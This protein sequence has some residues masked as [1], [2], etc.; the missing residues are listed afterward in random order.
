MTRYTYP[1]NLLSQTTDAD[2]HKVN[3]VRL[4]LNNSPPL[5]DWTATRVWSTP[6]WGTGTLEILQDGTVVY[7]D[8]GSG[9]NHPGAGMTSLPITVYFQVVDELGAYSNIASRP[10]FIHSPSSGDTTPP[11]PVSMSPAVGATNVA[12]GIA[13]IDL[14]FSEAIQQGAAGATI[15]LRNV[16]AGTDIETFTLP[17][18]VGTGPGKVSFSGNQLHVTPTANLPPGVMLALRWS[19]AAVKDLSR[20]D[21]T[22]NAGD[23]W[24]F[25]TA[26]LPQTGL[27]RPD[28]PLGLAGWSPSANYD[29]ALVPPGSLLVVD[30]TGANGAYT[31]ITAAMAAA[32]AGKTIAVK[33]GVYEEAFAV[34]AG[35]T[36]Q[37]YGTDKPLLTAQ[38]AL[39]GFVQCGA[40]DA[41]FLG[42]TLG[43]ASSPV[44]KKTGI[45]KSILPLTDLLG[46]LPMEAWA[47]L[48]NAQDRPDQTNVDFQEDASRFFNPVA[49]GGG[50]ILTGGLIT[51]ITDPTILTTAR[52]GSNAALIGREVRYFCAPNETA[53]ATITG[54]DLTTNTI[55]ITGKF[56]PDNSGQKYF[57]IQNWAPAMTPG[58]FAYI[59]N[60]TTFDL[61]IYPK[62]PANMSA[63]TIAARNRII[64]IP[65]N[66]DGVTIR[67]LRLCGASGTG[68]YNGTCITKSDSGNLSSNLLI[69]NCEVWGTYSSSELHHG[70][71][72]VV[73]MANVVVQYTTVR[74]TYAHGIFPNGG[75]SA[76]PTTGFLARR[77]AF[78]RTGSAGAKCYSM[79]NYVVMHCYHAW[80][81]YRSH[82]NLTNRY[83]GGVGALVYGCR[84]ERCQGYITFQSSTN[85]SVAFCH[86]PTDNKYLASGNLSLRDNR[87]IFNQGGTGTSFIFN[88]SLV[89]VF[90]GLAGAGH[91]AL[92]GGGD[93]I[94]VHMI[95]NITQGMSVP[96]DQ[97]GANKTGVIATCRKNLVTHGG[98][99]GAVGGTLDAADFDGST[100]KFDTSNVFQPATALVFKDYANRDWSPASA[101][102]PM[103]T[104]T[105][106]PVR[107]IIDQHFIPTYATGAYGVPASDFDLDAFGHTINW[108]GMRIGADMAIAA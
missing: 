33:A 38:Q 10:I 31:T 101:S 77:C 26:P 50:Y 105:P 62:S 59:D 23:A 28:D 52:Y 88:N 55:T 86:A 84:F 68:L 2:L 70:A 91:H 60:G 54:A 18:S 34:K 19:S 29:P 78:L 66:A 35:V 51:G 30:K 6:A 11:A 39:T 108:T 65:G 97:M 107:W 41:A 15:T 21:V 87:K 58:T 95:N 89:P 90:T 83:L 64:T 67:G 96:G 20:N 27:A 9:A 100:G 48:Y 53:R 49:N 43:V 12:V 37:G 7:D 71:I 17:G 32:S 76:A 3:L 81:G 102:S 5:I 25:S 22:A 93:G 79:S 1:E 42:P 74:D 44:Y 104:I 94:T 98:Y 73:K 75:S 13:T 4:G 99:S 16:T 46:C 14:T 47:P 92:F 40:G 56:A 85:A 36:L 24:E 103:L 45:L 69:E 82:G 72:W 57:A 61:Y 8:Q 63:I 106:D 80:C